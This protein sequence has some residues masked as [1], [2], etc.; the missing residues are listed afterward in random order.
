MNVYRTVHGVFTGVEALAL[1]AFAGI[2]LGGS[3]VGLALSTPLFILF[4]PILVP[5][6]IATTLLTTG[7][8]T[9]GGLG[10]VALRI[11]WKLFKRLRKKG[12]GT[13]KI[14]GLAPG[15]PDS[16]PVSGG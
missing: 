8:T 13:P 16:D 3:A 14:P 5:A 6:T 4:S 7:F 1:L 10:M 15:A 9:S 2:T 12:K 11:F